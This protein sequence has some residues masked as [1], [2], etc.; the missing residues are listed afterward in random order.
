MSEALAPVILVGC[1]KGGIGRTVIATNLSAM[2]ALAGQRTLLL[3]LDA[4]GD[5]TEGLGLARMTTGRSAA[6]L[7][8]PWSLLEDTRA[9]RRPAGLDVWPGGPGLQGLGAE[10]DRM[11]EAGQ[12]CLERGLELAR[13]R[14]RAVVIDAPPDLGPLAKNALAAADVLLIPITETA[15]AARALEETIDAACCLRRDMR[16]FAVRLLRDGD[17][18]SIGEDATGPLGVE[19]LD[20]VLVFDG[21]VLNEA[22]QLGLPVF[23]HAPA[24]RTARCF[25]ELGRE[26]IAKVLEPASELLR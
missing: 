11:G 2:L 14:Y 23:E 24:S 26:V 9:V 22:T 10:L 16:V 4:K 20:S 1:Q 17:V 13:Q 6:R 12:S 21:G 19:L 7:S 25:L 18:A 3:D 15:F 5:A 8:E